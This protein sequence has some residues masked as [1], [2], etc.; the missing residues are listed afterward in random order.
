MAMVRI[1]PVLRNLT[2]DATK[3]AA[4]GETLATLFDD[5]FDRYPELRSRMLDDD[6]SLQ[7][8]IN[9][10]VDDED[11]RTR[12]G[13]QTAVRADSSVIILPAMAGGAAQ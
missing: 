10:Y 6:G 7:R 3:V 5:L 9:V 1:P 2:D 8:F 13:L 11:V 4:D 12:D